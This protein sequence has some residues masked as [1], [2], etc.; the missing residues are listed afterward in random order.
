[1]FS[2]RR[3]E[4]RPATP[5]TVRAALEGREALGRALGVAVAESW[6]PEYL[7]HPALAFTLQ[8]LEEFPVEAGWWLGFLILRVPERP[9]VLIG[10]AGYKG[11]PTPDGTVEIGYGIVAEFHRQGYASEAAEGLIV[12]AF[13][14]PEVRRIIAETLPELAGS[15]GVLRRCGFVRNG[16]G[17]EPGVIRFELQRAT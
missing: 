4:Y 11:P 15:I 13:G 14:L 5:S 2:T 7:D 9:P 10:S 16:E 6:P 17:S 8:R 12:Q 3:L 1:M